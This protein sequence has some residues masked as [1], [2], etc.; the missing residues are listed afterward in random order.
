MTEVN[1]YNNSKIYKICSYLTN[2]FYI[3]STTQSISQRLSEHIKGYK[4]YLKTNTHYIT[5]YDIIKLNDSYIVLIEECNY[6]NKQQL[7]R[8]EGEIIKQNIN[9]AVNKIIVGRTDKEYYIDN[10]TKL[11]EYY[12]QYQVENKE[13]KAEQ[14]KR[15]YNDNKEKAKQ[16]YNDNKTKIAEREKRYYNNNKPILCECGLIKK[17]NNLNKHIK[18]IKHFTLI[19]NLYL[20]ELNFFNI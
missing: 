5:S 8:R 14:N 13:N 10:K 9:I 7:E 1:R 12:K 17:T 16:Y 20:N 2:K 6:N 15:Y 18:T 11:A 4:K 19:N 3:G